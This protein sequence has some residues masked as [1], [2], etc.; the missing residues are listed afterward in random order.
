MASNQ[1]LR[2]IMKPYAKESFL[3]DG[4]IQVA[5]T[6]ARKLIFGTP[7]E[8]V[9]Y[10][11]PVA[12]RLR[13]QGHYVSI[14]YTTRKE[15]IKNVERLVVSEELLRLKALNETMSVEERRTF[16]LNWKKENK[17]LLVSQLGSKKDNLKFVH[18]VFFAPSFSTKTVP[19]LQ[20]LYMA[21]ACHLNFGKYT[22]FCCYGVTANANMSPVAFGI[23][24]GNENGESWAEFWEFVKK[25]HPSM[26]IGDVT[27]ITDQDKGQMNAIEEWMPEAGHFHCSHHRRGNIIK[28]RGGGGGK[29]KYSALWMYNK[30]MGCRTVKQIQATKDSCFPHMDRKDIAYLNKLSDTSQYPAAR[31]NMRYDVYMY[32]R[33]ASAGAESMN[34]ANFSIRQR[35]SVDLNNAMMLLIQLE[36]KRYR[37][38]QKEAWNRDGVFTSRGNLEFEASFNDLYHTQF[39]ITVAEMDDVWVCSVKRIEMGREHSVTIPKEPVRGSHFGRCTCGVDR[40]DSAPCEHMAA[41]AAS[42]CLPGVTRHNVMPYWWTRAHWRMQIPQEP[43]GVTNVSM[44]SIIADNEPD[45]NLRYC[46]DWTANQKSGRPKKDKRKKSVLESATG[47]KGTKRA[48]GVKR[49]RRYCQICGKYNHITNECWKLGSNAHKRPG[50]FLDTAITV[51]GDGA[52]IDGTEGNPD[53]SEESNEEQEQSHEDSQTTSM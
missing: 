28:N 20:R 42:S 46:P 8:N 25:L 34:A 21:D 19:Q 48:T 2:A 18:G 22:L 39:R 43:L 47:S 41:V 51:E 27:I 36:C 5:R 44:S 14:K 11:H 24:F 53:A 12:T 23:V 45:H 17:Q 30:L 16:V 4:I 1:M 7:S 15:T 49:A 37:K 52:P 33:Q 32:H 40:Q 35:T 9:E 6:T 29:I 3:T 26:D 31:C 13:E 10:T 50:F 38:Q